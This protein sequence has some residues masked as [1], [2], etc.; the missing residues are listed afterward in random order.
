MRAQRRKDN[1]EFKLLEGIPPRY[2]GVLV[3]KMNDGR[4]GEL[5]GQ[6]AQTPLSALELNAGDLIIFDNIHLRPVECR[7]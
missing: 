7:R 1:V 3:V 5:P 2:V 4:G 6:E